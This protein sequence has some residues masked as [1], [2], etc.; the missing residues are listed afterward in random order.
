MGGATR[1]ALS[2]HSCI[3]SGSLDATALCN[4][5]AATWQAAPSSSLPSAQRVAFVP[6]ALLGGAAVTPRRRATWQQSVK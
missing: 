2:E 4:I 1:L 5:N 6:A 3:L